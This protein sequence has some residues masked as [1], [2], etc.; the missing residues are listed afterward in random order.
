MTKMKH[1]DFETAQADTYRVAGEELRAFVERYDAPTLYDLIAAMDDVECWRPVLG[2]SGYFVSSWGRIKGKRVGILKENES[3]GYRYVSLSVDGVTTTNRVPKIV[4]EAFVGPRPFP[5]AQAAHGDGDKSNN[6]LSNLRWATARDNQ[7]DVD[8]HGNRCRGSDVCG[9][10]LSEG[11][12]P[13]IR[14]RIKAGHSCTE[15]AGDYDVS[16]STISLI[17]RNRIWKHV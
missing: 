3:K 8:R 10:V 2:A 7:A 14:S 11:D 17:K 12:I 4:L 15:I 6:R 1:D 13:K 5:E 9:A 16:V